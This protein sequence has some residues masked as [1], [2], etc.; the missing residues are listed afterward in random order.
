[1][2]TRPQARSKSRPNHTDSD[3][4]TV[5]R[6]N[7]AE[8]GG[9]QVSRGAWFN[10][11]LKGAADVFEYKTLCFYGTVSTSRGKTAVFSTEHALNHLQKVGIG[12]WR[13]PNEAKRKPFDPASCGATPSSVSASPSV[14][15]GYPGTTPTVQT[16]KP[17]SSLAALGEYAEQY[18]IAADIIEEKDLAF[19][20]YFL[21]GMTNTH[22]KQKYKRL[23]NDSGRNFIRVFQE[24]MEADGISM[25]AEDTVEAYMRAILEAGM[26][27]AT[28]A[29]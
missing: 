13:E 24:E 22:L 19:L 27:E 3:A 29:C 10:A 17:P 12:T 25:S 18:Q 8:W 1:M 15:G 23:S 5:L 16:P 4:S 7:A 21:D 14:H 20:N 11:K 2:S 6:S 28:Y 26:P 9:D